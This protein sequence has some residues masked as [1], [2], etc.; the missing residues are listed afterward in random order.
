MSYF[1]FLRYAGQDLCRY[2][3]QNVKKAD[4][5]VKIVYKK[6]GRMDGLF[7]VMTYSLLANLFS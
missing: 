2:F 4:Y 6:T 3:F 1:I 7:L 5:G